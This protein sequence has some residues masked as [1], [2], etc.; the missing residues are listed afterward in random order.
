MKSRTL[1]LIIAAV[2]LIAVGVL[3]WPEPEEAQA[4]PVTFTVHVENMLNGNPVTGLNLRI[5]FHN[6]QQ[7]EQDWIDM[8]PDG[9]GNYK[10][11]RQA[12][13]QHWRVEMDTQYQGFVVTLQSPGAQ[14]YQPPDSWNSFTW[15]V[16]IQGI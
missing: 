3:V 4:D 8:E 15:L 12:S 16:T 5:K 13:Y 9:Q 1:T 6:G 14:P 10:Y 7:W 11:Q 2:M